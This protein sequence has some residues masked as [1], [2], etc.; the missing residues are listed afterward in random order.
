MVW[1]F[2]GELFPTRYRALGSS[3]LLTADLVANAI[4]AQLFPPLLESIGGAGVFAVFGVLALLAFVVVF[5]WAPETKERRLE[6]I[7]KYWENGARW[8]PQAPSPV[9]RSAQ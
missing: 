7:Q 4:V 8:E 9:V 1:V 2:A 6:E 5:R 3:I